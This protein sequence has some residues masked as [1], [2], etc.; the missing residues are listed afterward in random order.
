MSLHVI[1]YDIADDARRERL[2]LLLSGYGPRVQM[3]VF[4]VDL[5]TKTAAKELKRLIR[6]VID[7]H[8]DQVR[9]YPIAAESVGAI[10]IMGARMIEERAD[11]WIVR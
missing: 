6:E 11:F 7:R 10:S 3:S 4:E 5:P 2:S 8:E 1:A 9:I